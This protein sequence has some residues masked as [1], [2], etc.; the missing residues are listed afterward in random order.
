MPFPSGPI[1]VRE[2][3]YED[4]T[5]GKHWVMPQAN[6]VRFLKVRGVI[7][8]GDVPLPYK[9]TVVKYDLS[10]DGIPWVIF[11]NLNDALYKE[12]KEG[13]FGTLNVD[14][15]DRWGFEQVA[16]LFRA[17]VNTMLTILTL[18][19]GCP[20]SNPLAPPA[21]K[22]SLSYTMTITCVSTAM[23][24]LSTRKRRNLFSFCRSLSTHIACS[25]I[26]RYSG[27]MTTAPCPCTSRIHG[28][29]RTPLGG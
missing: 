11:S 9:F 20:Y 18:T 10:I 21:E 1:S 5:S 2:A 19:F 24:Q 27:P 13:F 12:F 17:Q 25:Q 15:K 23:E 16:W 14:R 22:F 4:V 28:C 26:H 6:D 8:I 7:V 29:M 3:S